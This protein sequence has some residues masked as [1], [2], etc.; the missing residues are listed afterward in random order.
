[1]ASSPLTITVHNT[2]EL[3]SAFGTIADGGT[4]E[5]AAGNYGGRVLLRDQSFAQGIT[6]TSEDPN[7]RAVITKDLD[8]LRVDGVTITGI[9]VI[10]SQL[11]P[12]TNFQH[13]E[14]D[15]SKNVVLNDMV[16]QGH[17]PTAS[18]GVDPNSA[19]NR[20]QVITG[21]GYGWGL[22]STYTQNLTV[23][24]V[25][26]RDLRGS[27]AFSDVTNANFSSIEIHDVREG[28]N[29]NDVRHILIEDSYFHDFKPW[30]DPNAPAGGRHFPEFVPFP[31]RSFR[32]R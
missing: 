7:N 30:Q 17:I 9:D 11:A 16:I 28:I 31:V 3:I 23:S 6:I 1:M 15:Q 13:V 8:L 32:R 18:E 10:A 21:Y 29:M 22:S 12:N 24:N 4:I 26:I 5:M 25:E 27:L 14:V 2:S 19:S 20:D